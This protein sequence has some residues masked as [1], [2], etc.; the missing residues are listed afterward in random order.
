ME[1]VEVKEATTNNLKI[2]QHLLG[3]LTNNKPTITLNNLDEIIM[4]PHTHL[5][6]ATDDEHVAGML[7]LC[8]YR[9]PTGTKA[10]IE[11]VV[12]AK[13]FQGKGW[14]KKLVLHAIKFAQAIDANSILLTSNP[15][16][17]TANKL[18][19]NIGFEMRETNVYRIKLD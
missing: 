19:Q 4:S 18:Y 17:I 13:D 1:I 11:D 9:S 8:L 6:F 2:I 12:V 7:T 16:R 10:W 14:G 3:F 5:F 15:T